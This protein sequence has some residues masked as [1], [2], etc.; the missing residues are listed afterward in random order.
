VMVVIEAPGLCG[1]AIEAL[2][3][4]HLDAIFGI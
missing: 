3:N 1:E 4:L 2:P